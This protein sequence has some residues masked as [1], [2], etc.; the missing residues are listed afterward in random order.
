M[1]RKKNI[2]K[3]TKWFFCNIVTRSNTIYF[4]YL[5]TKKGTFKY[6]ETRYHSTFTSQSSAL[7]H[8]WCGSAGF[9]ASRR[10]MAPFPWKWT[11]N[12]WEFRDCFSSVFKFYVGS[13]KRYRNNICAVRVCVGKSWKC[14]LLTRRRTRSDVVVSRRLTN[15]ANQST[16]VLLCSACARES[17]R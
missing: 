6:I 10:W 15:L 16:D 14:K 11:A 8:R 9:D 3:F 4:T 2:C 12:E 1:Y 5:R 7:T 13:I 17:Y